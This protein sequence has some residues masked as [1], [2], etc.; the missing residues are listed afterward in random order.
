MADNYL[1]RLVAEWY[2]Y[3][4][5]FVRRNVRVGKLPRGGYECELDV[6]AFNPSEQHLV[7]VEPSMD[8]DSWATREKRF[9]K[10]FAAGRKYIGD[11]FQGFDIPAHIEQIA[12]LAVASK[13]NRQT[14][15]GGRILLAKELIAEILESLRSKGL[16]TEAVPEHL[17]ILRTLQL[18]CEYRDVVLRTWRTGSE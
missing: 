7:Q 14:L 13:K 1:E 9:S 15:A 17:P 2:E 6:V 8:A 16:M 4:G 3:Q 12:L 11:I 10:K 18:I 5:Y